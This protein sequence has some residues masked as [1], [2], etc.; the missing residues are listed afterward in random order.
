[1]IQ[2]PWCMKYFSSWR[3]YQYM[4]MNQQQGFTFKDFPHHVCQFSKVLYE[5]KQAPCAL[6]GKIVE[7]HI[8]CWFNVSNPYSSLFVKVESR[9]HAVVILY[10]DGMNVIGDNAN[11]I[12]HPWE[13]FVNLVW[14]EEFGRSWMLTW[15]RSWKGMRYIDS[16]IPKRDMLEAY[17]STLAW[18]RQNQ[19]LHLWSYI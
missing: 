6:Y 1:M 14:N 3:D 9:M 19:W 13:D 17:W 8:F 18:R 2:D 11:E 10:V 16:F 7:Y 4:F 5:L 12:S 15:F